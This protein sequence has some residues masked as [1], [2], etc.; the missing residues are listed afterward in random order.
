MVLQDGFATFPVWRKHQ[1][2]EILV[3]SKRS[4]HVAMAVGLMVTNQRR[5]CQIW[6]RPR[7]ATPSLSCCSN[8]SGGVWI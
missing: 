4:R 5:Y 2:E 6:C 1:C 3:G 8:P 7:Q